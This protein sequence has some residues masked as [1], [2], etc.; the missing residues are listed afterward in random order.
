M[1]P[2]LAFYQADRKSIAIGILVL[3]LIVAVVY[4]ISTGQIQIGAITPVGEAYVTATLSFA[5]YFGDD[6]NLPSTVDV[7]VFDYDQ[8]T[9]LLTTLNLGE[10]KTISTTSFAVQTNRPKFYV[11]VDTPQEGMKLWYVIYPPEVNDEAPTV[12]SGYT[13]YPVDLKSALGT[14]QAN[15]EYAYTMNIL[16][17]K[18]FNYT[19]L[20]LPG[21]LNIT[22]GFTP[23]EDNPVA[24]G[25]NGQMVAPED[26]TM[27]KDITLYIIVPDNVTPTTVVFDGKA[28]ELTK[29]NDTTYKAY[30]GDTTF[31]TNET[32]K[33]L[34]VGLDITALGSYT[35]TIKVEGTL[36]T[37]AKQIL[38]TAST[39]INVS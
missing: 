2:G 24:V 19:G 15:Q 12:I 25:I 3:V 21:T 17:A 34:G 14:L 36:P 22:A 20:Q 33:T 6:E 39:T 8:N 38:A 10:T 32:T 5:D 29:I 26:E 9:I 7:R 30:I 37:G 16:L 18:T 31:P 23:S 35:V 13:V 4:L 27:Y 28:Y 11:G 1:T